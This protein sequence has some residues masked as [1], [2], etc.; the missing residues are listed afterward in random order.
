[1]L[2]DVESVSLL[3]SFPKKPQR[4]MSSEPTIRL[5]SRHTGTSGSRPN[6]R[7][8]NGL[9]STRRMLRHSSDASLC[10]TRSDVKFAIN[11]NGDVQASQHDVAPMVYLDHCALRTISEDS[12]FTA[13]LT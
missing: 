13:R 9:I 8:A 10:K 11:T 1:M 2:P 12:A 5:E 6:G 7:T 4:F 3:Y